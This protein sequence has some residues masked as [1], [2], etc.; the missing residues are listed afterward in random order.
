MNLRRLLCAGCGDLVPDRK[1]EIKRGR[2]M[3]V[4]RRMFAGSELGEESV[5]QDN[6]GW[7]RDIV[8]E[9]GGNEVTPDVGGVE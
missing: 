7:E 4:G 9:H 8:N 5:L 2:E 6:R 1:D 3:G